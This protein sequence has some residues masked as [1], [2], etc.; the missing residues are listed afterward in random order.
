MTLFTPTESCLLFPLMQGV[1]LSHEQTHSVQPITLAVTCTQ[2]SHIII[3][4]HA[5]NAVDI[6]PRSCLFKNFDYLYVDVL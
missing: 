1:S 2:Y 4:I 6:A 3:A 5:L